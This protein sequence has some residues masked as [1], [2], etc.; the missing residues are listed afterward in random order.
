M[1]ARFGSRRNGER[2]ERGERSEG[3]CG[4]VQSGCLV[5]AAAAAAASGRRGVGAQ[6]G[7]PSLR[8]PRGRG[9]GRGCFFRSLL[10]LFCGERERG[11]REREGSAAINPTILL[12]LPPTQRALPSPPTPSSPPLDKQD[13]HT[14]HHPTR[15][16]WG[17]RR[18]A[19]QRPSPRPAPRASPSPGSLA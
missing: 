5:D 4:W 2:G 16:G 10:S 19:A 9:C 18:L 15:C 3:V 17:S 13:P 11:G 1:L 14:Q 8:G 6:W 12:L 7:G